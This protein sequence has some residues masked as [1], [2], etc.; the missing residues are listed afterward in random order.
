M[1]FEGKI[2]LKEKRDARVPAG[3]ARRL[4]RF[5]TRMLPGPL[6]N[7]FLHFT[8]ETGSETVT[9]ELF[10][11]EPKRCPLARAFVQAQCGEGDGSLSVTLTTDK[12]AF[13]VSLDATGI[14][15]E[16]DDNCFT[17]LAGAPRVLAFA[18]R[19]PVT[20]GQLRKALS[21]RHLRETYR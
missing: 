13:S 11:A 16:F 14:P 20:V 21:V 18:P 7:A 19:K 3:R 2:L 9:N 1:D 4:A 5:P 6:E 8:L 10:L 15:G 12:P 17:L